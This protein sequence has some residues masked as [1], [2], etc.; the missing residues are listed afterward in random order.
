MEVQIT[1][2]ARKQLIDIF[3][4][5]AKDQPQNASQLILRILHRSDSLSGLHSRG[6]IVPE[7]SDPAVRE[8]FESGFRIIYRVTQNAVQVLAIVHSRRVLARDL[9]PSEE[10]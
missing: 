8:I 10:L 3:D 4:Y 6:R 9:V 1:N 2:A 5:I 7:V